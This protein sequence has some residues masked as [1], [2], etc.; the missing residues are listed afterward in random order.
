[1][2]KD[3]ADE[4]DMALRLD[5]ITPHRD[6]KLPDAVRNRLETRLPKWKESAAKMPINKAL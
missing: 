4:A 6:K 5:R 1:M 3:A 2:Y